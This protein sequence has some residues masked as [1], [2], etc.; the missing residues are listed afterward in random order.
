MPQIFYNSRKGYKRMERKIYYTP[1]M[2]VLLKKQEDVICTSAD[3]DIPFIPSDD[4][5]LGDDIFDV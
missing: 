5:V 4:D 1:Y 2:F 3:T